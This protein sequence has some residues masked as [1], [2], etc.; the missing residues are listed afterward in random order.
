MA[1][2]RP[3]SSPTKP[4]P[5]TQDH[6]PH[7]RRGWDPNTPQR[8]NTLRQTLQSYWWPDAEGWIAKYVDNCEQCH[9]ALPAIK[10]T[11]STIPSLHLKIL[12]A[13]KATPRYP[14]NMGKPHTQS[15]KTRV[16]SLKDKRLVIPPDKQLKCEIF[17]ITTRR[18]Y[19]G[20]PRTRRD[21]HSSFPSV[22]VAWD[23][24]RGSQTTW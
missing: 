18:A 14:R 2:T 13:Q 8:P 19:R 17:A 9:S 3:T 1:K 23:E 11:S 20:T 5:K 16:T 21:L 6:V 7:S 15:K 4:N 24:K 22:L 12:E 10:T